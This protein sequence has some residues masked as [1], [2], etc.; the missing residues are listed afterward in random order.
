MRPAVSPAPAETRGPVSVHPW[1]YSH[2]EV[3]RRFDV[4]P[5][6]GLTLEEAARRRGALGPNLVAPDQAEA[7]DADAAQPWWAV[8]GS[9]AARWTGVQ[10]L[11]DALRRAWAT[12]TDNLADVEAGRQQFAARVLRSDRV[13]TVP[14]VDLV[15]GDIVLLAQGDLIPADARLLDVVE[16]RVDEEPLTGGEVASTRCVEPVGSGWTP[17]ADR[18]SMVHAG[19][20]VVYGAGTAVVVATGPL[21]VLGRAALNRT[22]PVRS[23]LGRASLSRAGLRRTGLGRPNGLG[24]RGGLG[25][26]ADRR[27]ASV[28]STA[29][30]AESAA[31]AGLP[32]PPSAAPPS[33]PALLPSLPRLSDAPAP[34]PA[35]LRPLV[36]QLRSAR[37]GRTNRR[38][39]RSCGR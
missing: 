9:A 31:P 22:T 33:P 3:L 17:L 20:R 8:F 30:G 23:T 5:L 11:V 1:A 26:G 32:S 18:R 16:L 2:D 14:A 15:P 19:S 10:A 21:T 36:L 12:P 37:S 6:T 35:E 13:L 39:T 24:R 28:S 27:T 7:T 29:R 34:L 38:W 25:A 4:N